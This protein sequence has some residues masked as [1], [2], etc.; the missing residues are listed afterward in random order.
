M[1]EAFSRGRTGLREVVPLGRGAVEVD[2]ADE[3]ALAQ[4]DAVHERGLAGTRGPDE[5][6]ELASVGAAG[7][8]AQGAR[9]RCGLG[10]AWGGKWAWEGVSGTLGPLAQSNIQIHAASRPVPSTLQATPVPPLAVPGHALVGHEEV[11]QGCERRGKS[12]LPTS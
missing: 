1:K 6:R 11:R 4:G 3:L 8:R 7:C 12:Y 10:G 5:R 9:E 2:G